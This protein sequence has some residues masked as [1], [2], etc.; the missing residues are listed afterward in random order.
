ML[1]RVWHG[2]SRRKTTPLVGF[3][4]ILKHA[5]A[6][7]VAITETVLCVR[8]PLLGGLAEPPNC[9]SIVLGDAFTLVI[10]RAEIVLGCCQTLLSGFAVPLHRLDLILRHA[11]AIVVADAQTVLGPRNAALG[12]DPIALYLFDLIFE[13]PSAAH[14]CFHQGFLPRYAL[15]SES[16]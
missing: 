3:Y 4:V 5:L 6:V 14:F 10:T 12:F 11:F 9:L 16:L 1:L 2:L 15:L 7:M 13:P 8:L